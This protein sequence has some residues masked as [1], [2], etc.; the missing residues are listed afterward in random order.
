VVPLALVYSNASRTIEILLFFIF[1]P[2][3][4]SMAGYPT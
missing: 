3:S 1:H 4:I 2:K